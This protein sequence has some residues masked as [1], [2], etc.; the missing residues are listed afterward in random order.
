M[1]H[2]VGMISPVPGGVGPRPLLLGT[3]IPAALLQ[4]AFVR[5]W[6]ALGLREVVET[7]GRAAAKPQ[8]VVEAPATR[9]GDTAGPSQPSFIHPSVH[10]QYLVF[11]VY[12]RSQGVREQLD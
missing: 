7:G 3:F 4:A 8:P 10:G 6:V 1:A 12:S 5:P 2:F 9:G 11:P